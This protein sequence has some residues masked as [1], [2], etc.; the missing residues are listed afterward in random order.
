MI[1][2]KEPDYSVCRIKIFRPLIEENLKTEYEAFDF[3][4]ELYKSYREEVNKTKR[5]ISECY[6]IKM[7]EQYKK[8]TDKMES[9][10]EDA[11]DESVKKSLNDIKKQ[12]KDVW[13]NSDDGK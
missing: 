7:R 6:K 2:R 12:I 1:L 4:K 3:E 11:L 8:V 9:L 5:I 10:D 13:G